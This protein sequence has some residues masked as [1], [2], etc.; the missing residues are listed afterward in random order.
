MH[1]TIMAEMEA[2]GGFWRLLDDFWR[3]LEA[4]RVRVLVLVLVLV[5]VASASVEIVKRINNKT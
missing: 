4:S 5:P 3:L 2:S 1:F